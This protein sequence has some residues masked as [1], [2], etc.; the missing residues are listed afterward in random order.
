[1]KM[2]SLGRLTSLAAVMTLAARLS[3]AEPALLTLAVFEFD[4]REGGEVGQNVS[5]LLNVQLSAEANLITVERAELAKV[6][7]EQELSLSGTVSAETA[8]KVG[9]LTGA[10]VLVTGRIFKTGD[11]TVLVAKIISTETSRVYGEMVKGRGAPTDLAAE[12]GQK[13]AKTVTSKSDTLVAKVES[14][15]E[16]IKRIKEQLKEAKRP[17][18]FVR[19]PERHYGALVRDPAAET[20]LIKVLQ[21]TG[22]TV[23]ETEAKADLVIAGE[24]FSTA[25]GRKGNLHICKARVEIKA[26]SPKNSEIVAADRETSVAVDL[27]EET[28]AKAALQHAAETLAERLLP[29]LVK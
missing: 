6:L 22:F 28:A 16:R 29:K 27:A 4:T 2:T 7:G 14:R 11:D 8:A 24:A 9:H 12:L 18:V 19:V 25:A 20:E 26:V 23:A 15:E 5:A 10:K 21:E 13:I 17:T 1:M 3:G